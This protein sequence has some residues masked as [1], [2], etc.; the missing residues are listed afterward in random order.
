MSVR[1]RFPS[2]ARG[3]V[4]KDCPILRKPDNKHF[5]FIRLYF[6]LFGFGKLLVNLL[7]NK[8]TSGPNM[9]VKFYLFTRPDKQGDHPINVSISLF[10]ELLCTS[11]GY[12]IAPDE[13]EYFLESRATPAYSP[14]CGTVRKNSFP[15]MHIQQW[16]VPTSPVLTIN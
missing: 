13:S 14:S 15:T 11:V 16:E 4:F 9:P 2:G 10:G 12:A 6:M 7:A 3:A 1:V 8:L 5:A